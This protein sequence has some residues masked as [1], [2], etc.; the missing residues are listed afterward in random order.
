MGWEEG[1]SSERILK[2]QK[3]GKNSEEARGLR[4]VKLVTEV[5]P[6]LELEKGKMQ[7]NTYLLNLEIEVED[8][9]WHLLF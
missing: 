8:V 2:V 9:K 4:E 6:V 3:R 5:G 1:F 7:I